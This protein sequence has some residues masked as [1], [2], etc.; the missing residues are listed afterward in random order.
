MATLFYHSDDVIF[1]SISTIVC[2]LACSN[3]FTPCPFWTFRLNCRV[4]ITHLNISPQL[5]TLGYTQIHPY[6]PRYTQI[7]SD[8]HATL[9]YTQIHSVTLGNTQIHSDTFRYIQIHMI[10]SIT[11][12]YTQ[13]HSDTLSYTR[14]HSVTLRYTQ[15]HSDTL[16]Y[17]H[18]HSNRLR[19][20]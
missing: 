6:I 15:L 2:P 9:N 18:I 11:L 5:T 1:K 13:I 20:T 4:K 14:I 10:H 16:S 19:K 17:T 12:R 3:R 7:H 8:T